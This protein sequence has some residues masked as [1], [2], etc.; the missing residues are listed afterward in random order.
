MKVFKVTGYTQ[1]M[2]NRAERIIRTQIA[3]TA[4]QAASDATASLKALVHQPSLL[5]VVL[6]AEEIDA[7]L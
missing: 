5:R 3:D 1:F 2:T 7:N 4:D 6:K